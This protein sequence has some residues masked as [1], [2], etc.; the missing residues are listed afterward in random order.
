MPEPMDR[1]LVQTGLSQFDKVQGTLQLHDNGALVFRP[2]IWDRPSLV[3]A[4][5]TWIS[6]VRDEDEDD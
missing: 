2:T 4:R 6:V 3:M 1:W 5:G